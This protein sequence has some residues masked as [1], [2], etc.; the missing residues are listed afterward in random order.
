MSRISTGLSQR[1]G[2]TAITVLLCTLTWPA[3][4][5]RAS[6]I[7]TYT[8]NNYTAFFPNPGNFNTYT[9]Q[10]SVTGTIT[11][12]NPLD[13]NLVST[14]ISSSS[15]LYYAVSD[16]VITITPDCCSSINAVV[17]TDA[18]GN[19]VAPYRVSVGLPQD[20]LSTRFISFASPPFAPFPP[21]GEINDYTGVFSSGPCVPPQC[22]R[23][24]AA[25]YVPGT[26]GAIPEPTTGLL[27]FAGLLGLAG[28][29]RTQSLAVHALA[30]C[31]KASASRTTSD[32]D[33]AHRIAHREHDVRSSS[34]SL[35]HPH[36]TASRLFGAR[37]NSYAGAP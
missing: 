9:N 12:A 25:S 15:I 6:A 18:Y 8:G 28:W 7:Y 26:W 16:G 20:S 34:H 10:M 5:A 21:G 22:N 31:R 33:R 4:T 3:A 2:L 19:I 29:R 23:V 24:A 13:P 36:V 27:V 11:L 32:L 17:S 30:C 35:C 14:P 37:E 1:F